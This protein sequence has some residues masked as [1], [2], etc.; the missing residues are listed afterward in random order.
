M[1]SRPDILKELYKLEA[2][3]EGG[4]FAEA[5]TAPFEKDGRS[6]AGSIYFLLDAG[7]VSQFHEIDCDELWFFHEGCGVRI[8]V[9]YQDSA[10]EYLLGPDCESSQ[11]AMIAI[12]K[13]AIFSAENLVPDGFTFVSCVTAPK[14]RYE[15]F[16]LVSSEEIHRK[17][18]TI[19]Q[20][21]ERTDLQ[22][23][24]RKKVNFYYDENGLLRQYPT[25][26]PLRRIVLSRI[27]E[28]FALG[29]A[30]TERQVN[31]II[32]DQIAFSDVELI[33][34]ELYEGRYIDR[35]RDGSKYWRI[36]KRD[37]Q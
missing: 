27:A 34:R 18:P 10:E 14:F 11:R 4:W 8:T 28:R 1:Q 20:R 13:G 5:Y 37:M 9:L 31:Q 29:A 22:E 19:L 25:K 36:E 17:Y 15:G 26:R 16:R 33:R 32:A 12:P 21:G 35:L 6:L 30:Y 3:P 2:H 7:E 23:R 24:Y